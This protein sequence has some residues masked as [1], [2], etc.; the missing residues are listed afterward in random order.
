[1][2]RCGLLCSCAA[3]SCDMRHL[4]AHANMH[5]ATSLADEEGQWSVV[6]AAARALAGTLERLHF[7]FF[8]EVSDVTGHHADTVLHQLQQDLPA[9]LCRIIHLTGVPQQQNEGKRAQSS[10]ASAALQVQSWI[11]CLLGVHALHSH[12]LSMLD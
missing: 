5:E 4:C 10:A 1:M 12:L 9:N 3:L 2:C 6:A 8:G 7:C 11:C